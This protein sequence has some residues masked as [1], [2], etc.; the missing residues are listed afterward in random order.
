MFLTV[1]G[2]FGDPVWSHGTLENGKKPP[3]NFRHCFFR[4]TLKDNQPILINAFLPFNSDV[5]PRLKSATD[6]W[7]LLN[8]NADSPIKSQLGFD[9]GSSIPFQKKIEFYHGSNNPR[10]IIS[11][12]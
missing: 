11:D 7:I 1:F 5:R 8:K 10:K 4:S 6:V 9:L 12:I 3:S 2:F